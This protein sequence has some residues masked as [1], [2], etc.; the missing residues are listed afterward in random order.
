MLDYAKNR[1]SG[2]DLLAVDDHLAVCAECRLAVPQPASTLDEDGLSQLFVSTDERHLP[3][4]QMSR[5]IEGSLDDVDLEIARLHLSDC[6]D[7]RAETD[8]MASV[9]SNAEVSTEQRPMLSPVS[10][11]DR[12]RAFFSIRTLRFAIPIVIV[13]ALAGAAFWLT[14]TTPEPQVQTSEAI[15]PPTIDNTVASSEPTQL[16]Q[17]PEVSDEPAEPAAIALADAGRSLEIGKDGKVIGSFAGPYDN[18][19]AA[20][21]TTGNLAIAPEASRLRSAAGVLMGSRDSASSLRLQYPVGKIVSSRRPQLRWT[22]VKGATEYTV[23]IFDANFNKVA[24]S[25]P[26][27]RTSWQ[28]PALPAGREYSW[29]VTAVTPE[30]KVKAPTR[31]APDAKF[32]V[33]SESKL[34]GIAAARRAYGNSHLVLGMVYAEAGLLDE[35]EREFTALLRKNPNS[36][37]VKRL[38]ARIRAAK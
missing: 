36:A 20:A 19:L 6:E 2:S 17:I 11:A 33:L 24:S 29:Q 30:A 15:T 32:L 38:L 21:L 16:E 8:S 31:P 23:E 34:N 10:T 9:Y 25:P 7:C 27:S 35:A 4:S 22:P 12:V 13:A 18:R 28:A 5:Y 37:A 14:R 26:L 1:L 3:F